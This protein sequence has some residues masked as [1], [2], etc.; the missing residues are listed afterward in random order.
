VRCRD[1]RHTSIVP[2][3][4]TLGIPGWAGLWWWAEPVTSYHPVGQSAD[5]L[6]G[7]DDNDDRSLGGLQK[8]LMRHSQY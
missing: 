6:I 4:V 2:W 5:R 3:V 7:G 1:P 8:E